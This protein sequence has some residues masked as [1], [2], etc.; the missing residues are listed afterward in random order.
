MEICILASGSKGNCIYLCGGGTALLIDAGLSAKETLLRMEAA[1]IDKTGIR[2][3]L[4]THDHSDH[5]RGARVLSRRLE[6]Q[7][8]ANDGTAAAIEACDPA[9]RTCFNIFDSC[10]PFVIGDLQ[11]EP[12]CVPHD[13]GDPVGFVIDDGRARVG[14]VTD[15]GQPT[16]LCKTKLQNCNLIVVESNHDP[17]MLR[18]SERPW[19]LIQ[20][21]EGRSGHLCNDD[22]A[23]LI[24]ES[25]SGRLTKI[26]LAHLSE[27]CNTP[28]LARE[29]T[30]AALDRI[31]LASIPVAVAEQ[32]KISDLMRI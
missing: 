2:S 11:I 14:I 24:A 9:L 30:L 31:G 16:L 3:I 26:V 4:F 8:Y 25:A 19:P 5:C 23:E 17:E 13:A 15:I 12:F 29:T 20:R 1:G 28:R 21:I 6:A 32:H 7:L 27:D 18:Q 10:C 22:A